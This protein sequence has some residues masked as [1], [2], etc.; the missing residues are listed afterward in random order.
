VVVGAGAAA[1]GT[2]AVLG[3]GDASTGP[4]AGGLAQGS[5]G[6]GLGCCADGSADRSAAAAMTW[7]G[8]G[9]AGGAVRADRPTMSPPAVTMI[10]V[11]AEAAT[12]ARRRFGG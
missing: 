8:T 11:P 10:A 6:P 3:A 12:A 5:A 4:G 1:S 2:V 9:A 7:G